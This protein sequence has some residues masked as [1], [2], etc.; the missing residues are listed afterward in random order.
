M[1][2]RQAH[3]FM[4]SFALKRTLLVFYEDKQLFLLR[5][6]AIQ[7]K[8]PVSLKEGKEEEGGDE[9]EEEEEAKKIHKTKKN[10]TS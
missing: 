1:D 8:E 3:K 2:M 6:S 5:K 9:E 7:D 4:Q 10:E